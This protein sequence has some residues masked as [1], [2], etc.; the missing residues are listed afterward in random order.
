MYSNNPSNYF[1]FFL[2]NE[3][4]SKVSSVLERTPFQFKPIHTRESLAEERAKKL[5]KSSDAEQPPLLIDPQ[6]IIQFATTLKEPSPQPTG[7][8]D[9]DAHENLYDLAKTLQDSL[10]HDRDLI[11]INSPADAAAEGGLSASNS[12][13]LLST[14]SPI[15]GYNS[16]E[17]AAEETPN[18]LSSPD[19]DEDE[20]FDG[21][22]LSMTED[23]RHGITN[24]NYDFDL[25]EHSSE[26]SAAGPSCSGRIPAATTSDKMLIED[27]PKDVLLPMPL[28]PTTVT[29][30]PPSA[31]EQ[32]A[33]P[34]NLL[35]HK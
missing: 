30:R 9:P 1:P 28:L 33:T 26:H 2:Q 17:L 15:F 32:Q 24:I 31:E 22:D 23:F 34:E 12:Q 19:N 4:K 13:D 25:S 7:L 35:I 10:E 16:F 3:I 21:V 5:D 27:S 29:R 8:T 20:D 6:P 14:V 18:S 11:A